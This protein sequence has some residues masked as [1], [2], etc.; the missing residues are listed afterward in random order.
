MTPAAIITSMIAAPTTADNSRDPGPLNIEASVEAI[1]SNFLV[2]LRI[3]R[4][5]LASSGL[6]C[7]SM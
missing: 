6:K 3:L 1:E 2:N 5:E 4:D 7:G